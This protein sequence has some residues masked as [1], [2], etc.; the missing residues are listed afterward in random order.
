MELKI[1]THHALPCRT[2]VFTINGKSAEQNDFGDTYDHHHEDAEPYACADMH[3]DP[4]PPTKEVL[5]R[6]NI[7]EEEYYNICNELECKLCVVGEESFS[8]YV[9]TLSQ[10]WYK[11]GNVHAGIGFL[12]EKE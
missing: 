7:T 9:M 11:L 3:F 1:K 10:S 8:S 6:Y 5:N 2:E 12:K 4:K